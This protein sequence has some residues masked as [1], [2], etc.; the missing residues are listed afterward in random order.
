MTIEGKME[1]MSTPNEAIRIEAE[2]KAKEADIRTIL[3][4]GDISSGRAAKKRSH[5][6]L[7]DDVL[8][9]QT[10]E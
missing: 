1:T 10:G 2:G 8:A 5:G 3:R 7:W 4:S 9:S 6:Q